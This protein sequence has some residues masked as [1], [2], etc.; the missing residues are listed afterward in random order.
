MDTLSLT[1][2]DLE[3]IAEYEKVL[4]GVRK[5]IDPFY[6]AHKSPEVNEQTTLMLIRYVCETYLQ[7]SPQKIRIS[8]TTDIL[9]KWHLFYLMRHIRFRP[10]VDPMQDT[11]YIACLLYPDLIK[12]DDRAVCIAV[13]ERLLSGEIK[14]F[15]KDFFSGREG[16]NRV[17]YCLKY[18]IDNY[19]NFTSVQDMYHFFGTNECTK[20][21]REWRLA[22]HIKELYDSPVTAFHRITSGEQEDPFLFNVYRFWQ[23]YNARLKQDEESRGRRAK[24]KHASIEKEDL[25]H[26]QLPL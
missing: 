10:E 3:V 21:L 4:T 6:F 7:W 26:A 12:V 22:T 15:P 5:A 18:A 24:H 19:T 20:S 1:E 8:L 23:V 9:K 14:K 2:L 11:G 16:M 13:Y 25:R 17:S